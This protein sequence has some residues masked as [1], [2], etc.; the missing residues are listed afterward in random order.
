LHLAIITGN[1][2]VVEYLVMECKQSPLTKDGSGMTGIELAHSKQ[3][4]EVE[5]LLRVHTGPTFLHVA[6][7]MGMRRFFTCG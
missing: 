3:R 5:W 1:L 2:S 4:S 6:R 7:G